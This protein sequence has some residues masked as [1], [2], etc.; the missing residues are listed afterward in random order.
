[1]RYEEYVL[2]L[3]GIFMGTL[4]RAVT[5]RVDSR[6]N[7]SFPTGY[8]INLVTGFYDKN[9]RLIQQE[10]PAARKTSQLKV[11][12]KSYVSHTDETIFEALEQEIK[13]GNFNKIQEK[14]SFR[15][16]LEE[17]Y[18]KEKINLREYM[19]LWGKINN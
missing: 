1:M 3:G 15:S 12:T 19:E 2:I 14:E 6:Q 13:N 16:K 18:K 5:L 8:F 10:N 4:A 11:T 17:Y 7:P 9:L